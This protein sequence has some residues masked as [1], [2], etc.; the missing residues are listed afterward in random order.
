MDSEIEY[1]YKITTASLDYA[2]SKAD[3]IDLSYVQSWKESKQEIKLKAQSYLDK[4]QLSKLKKMWSDLFEAIRETDEIGEFERYLQNNYGLSILP[5]LDSFI[6]RC[7]KIIERGKVTSDSQ[8][9]ALRSY[10]DMIES[11]ES[12]DIKTIQ[13]IDEILDSYSG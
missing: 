12:T 4:K 1:Y 3:S 5:L 8:Y 2:L 7:Q 11:E 13:R 6:K 10:L 9:Y